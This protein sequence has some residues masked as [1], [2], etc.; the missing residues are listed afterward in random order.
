MANGKINAKQIDGL[1]SIENGGTNNSSF[2]QSEILI[3]GTNSI[4][5]SGYLFNDF[6][7]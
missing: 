7:T 5:S 4:N 2:T 1:V 6:G 3:F